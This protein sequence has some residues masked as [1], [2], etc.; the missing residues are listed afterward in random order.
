MKNERIC[1]RKTSDIGNTGLWRDVHQVHESGNDRSARQDCH[2]SRRE[3]R[4]CRAESAGEEAETAAKKCS[5]QVVQ[6]GLYSVRD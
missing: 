2:S 3:N 5:P 4:I 1:S 6:V